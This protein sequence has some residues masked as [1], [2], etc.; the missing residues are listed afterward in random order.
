MSFQDKVVRI[1]GAS[2]GI[3]KVPPLELSK[4][5]ALLIL[6]ARKEQILN[7]VK[8]SCSDPER[9]KILHLNLENYCD[10]PFKAKNAI[11]SFGRL[12]FW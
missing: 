10:F 8:E 1:T 9:V 6:S 12:M 5:G 2:F 3:G 7:E 11:N 4:Q